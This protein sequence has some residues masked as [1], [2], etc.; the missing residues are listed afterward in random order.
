MQG[1]PPSA[2]GAPPLSYPMNTP[3]NVGVV[4]LGR[5]GSLYARHFATRL[6][7][8]RLHSVTDVRSDVGQAIARDTGA[9]AFPDHQALVKDPALDAV[10]VMTRP[11][12]TARWSWTPPP[13]ARRSS[14]RNP[15][16]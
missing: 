2:P 15:C 1:Y 10:V 5:L 4:G 7:G 14:A 9:K 12:C 11:N 16:P 13:R 6:P 8:A 3:L